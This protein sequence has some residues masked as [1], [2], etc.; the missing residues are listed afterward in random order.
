MVEDVET[1][2]VRSG[3]PSS[4]GAEHGY[5]ERLRRAPW[6]LA[7]VLIVAVLGVTLAGGYL[8]RTEITRSWPPA[9]GLYAAFGVDVSVGGLIFSNTSYSRVVEDGLSVLIV[10][11]VLVNETDGSIPFS[12]IRASLRDAEAI[13]IDAWIFS[14]GE[15]VLEPGGRQIFKTRRTNPPA[16]AFDLELSIIGANG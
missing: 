15:G 8:F 16:N 14:A 6:L 4:A 11:G 3:W 5:D 2:I 7:L 12:D 13:E 10:E 9:K 1:D